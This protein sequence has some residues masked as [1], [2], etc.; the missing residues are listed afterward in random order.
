MP[1]S[2]QLQKEEQAKID[3]A[4]ALTEEE[5]EEKENLLQQVQIILAQHINLWLKC[6]TLKLNVLCL[7]LDCAYFDQLYLHCRDLLFGTNVTST[8]SSKPMKSGEEMISRTLPERLRE[9]LQKKSWNILVT[10][11]F[12]ILYSSDKAKLVTSLHIH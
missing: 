3:E 8:S 9:K 11:Q 5:L 12:I 2:A 1:N 10:P 7:G 6:H 4:E